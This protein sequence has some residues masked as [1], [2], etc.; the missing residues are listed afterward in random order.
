MKMKIKIFLLLIFIFEIKSTN[1]QQNN[2]QQDAFEKIAAPNSKKGWV[3]I[4]ENKKII[5]KAFFEQN[6]IAFGLGA[7]DE[8]KLYKIQN[9]ELG[10]TH[11]RYQQFYNGYKIMGAEYIVHERAGFVVSANGKIIEGINNSY[12]IT[13]NKDQALAKA[14]TQFGEKKYA[15]ESPTLEKQKKEILHDNKATYYPSMDLVLISLDEKRYQLCYLIDINSISL[16][17]RRFYIDASNGKLIS[18]E[19]LN[20]TCTGANATSVFNGS[21]NISTKLVSNTPLTYN[22]WND[23]NSK[24][25]HTLMWN[26]TGANYAEY[27]SSSTTWSLASSAATSHWGTEVASNYFGAIHSRNGWNGTGGGITIYQDATFGT[28][29]SNAAFYSNSGSMA[30][31]NN[32][33]TS[34]TIDDF[35][36]LDIVAHEFAHGVTGTSAGLV[37]E[38][39]PGALNESFS[40]IFGVSCYAWQQGGLNPNMWKVG[41][42]RSYSVSNFNSLYIRNMANPIDKSHPDTYLGYGWRNTTA[43]TDPGDNWGVHSNS[44]VQNFMYYLLVTGGTGTNDNNENYSVVGI[45]I[46]NARLIAYRALTVYLTTSSQYNNARD[47]WV[48]AA[49]DLFG[50]CSV[51][52]V[53][54]A[55]AWYA[56]GV[57]GNNVTG[58]IL[59]CGVINDL[60]RPPVYSAGYLL[61]SG[62]CVTFASLL[63]SSTFTVFTSGKQ[64]I[65]GPGFTAPNGSK[66]AININECLLTR[67]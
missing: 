60:G 25:V 29:Q 28:N 1:A 26:G 64:V 62:S 45:G 47:A 14:K 39:E 40:D 67:Y 18:T 36:T 8:M 13:L 23:C 22:L 46:N 52:A 21:I 27:T 31:G 11:Y 7:N 43:A 3:F 50:Y 2:K 56:V 17:A 9:D 66:L 65:I 35:N 30:I 33:T 44:G 4:K 55:Q 57:K 51:Q 59:V 61:Q 12:K 16:N 15:W 54:T 58:N 38:K 5:A 6:K 24:F 19:E 41:Y 53:Q 37:Y 32:G 49:E 63:P 48:H 10:F 34:T 20:Y 42:D